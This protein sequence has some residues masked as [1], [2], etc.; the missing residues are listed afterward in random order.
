[1][2][3]LDLSAAKFTSGQA[4]LTYDNF[5]FFAKD[6]D[7]QHGSTYANRGKNGTE[8]GITIVGNGART[9][10]FKGGKARDYN[11]GTDCYTDYDVAK[12][13][14]TIDS[15]LALTFGASGKDLAKT[16]DIT[17]LGPETIDGTKVEKLN[18]V[19]KDKGLKNNIDHI[20]LWTDLS[21][22]VTLKYI[23]YAPNKDTKTATYTDIK[24][25]QKVDTKAF[26]FKGKSC[27]K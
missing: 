19:P 10:L 9:I 23:D 17:D 11:P 2:H 27:S 8:V 6:D 1:M 18:L 14:G 24:V 15:F 7:I 21:R 25:N 4:N 13:K 22:G 16:W 26:A 3:Q 20:M 12:S 5:T